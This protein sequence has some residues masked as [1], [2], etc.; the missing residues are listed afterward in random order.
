[1][2]LGVVHLSLREGTQF[3]TPCKRK[4]A[5]RYAPLLDLGHKQTQQTRLGNTAWPQLTCYM[6]TGGK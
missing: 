3:K 6:M 2:C 5:Y 4:H 1:M